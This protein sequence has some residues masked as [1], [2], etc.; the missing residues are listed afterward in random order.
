L[1]RELEAGTG[2]LLGAFEGEELVGV[3]LAT[4]DGRK[5]WINRIAV[6]PD[7]RRAGTARALIRASEA[8]FHERGIGIV[9]CLIEDGNRPS[10]DLFESAGYEVRRDVV[11][12][13]KPLQ[14]EDW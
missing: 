4:D 13:R 6:L 3:A 11:Y 8:A 2:F 14:D 7:R 10:L 9:A 5:G 12:L 1:R